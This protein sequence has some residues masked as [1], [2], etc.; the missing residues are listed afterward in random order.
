MK[1]LQIGS[2]N[3]AEQ[4]DQMP[5]GMDWFVCQAKEIPKILEDLKQEALQKLPI[6]EEG[7]E[8]P[9]VRIY[10]DAVL[11]TTPVEESDLV[12]LMNTVEAYGL[13]YDTNLVLHTDN[14]NGIFR[15][16]VLQELP[17]DGSI[18]EKVNYLHL[19]LFGSQ[20][21]AKLKIPDIDINPN[22]DGSVRYD[23]H[24]ALELE[25]NFGEDFQP[26][27]TFRYNLSSFPVALELW[28]EFTKL[29]GDCQIQMEI[30]PM[31]KGGLYDLLPSIILEESDL[32]V[33]YVLDSKP[34]EIGFYAIS[35]FA[36][37]SGKMTFGPLHWRYSRIGLGKFVAGGQR[38]ND[39]S[40]QEFI[41]YFNPGDM[42]PPMNVYFSGYRPAEGFEGFGI[43]KSLK[44]PF[45]L[46]GDPRLEGGA[47]YIG[48][49]ELENKIVEVIQDSLNYLGFESNQLILSGL[50]MGTYGA[51]YYAPNLQPHAVV[52]G[53][54][55]TNLGD[56]AA[57]LKLKRPDEFE[58]SADI[59]LNATGGI[60]DEHI[61]ILNQ[62]FWEKFSSS[63]F[64]KTKFAIAYMENDDYDSHATLRLIEHLS[65][66]GA[67]IYTK[68]YEGRHNDNS[69][70]IN[71][72]FMRQYVDLLEAGFER[73][74]S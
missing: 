74:Y 53:K 51:L 26:L 12:P 27:F 31:R 63:D 15:R 34:E 39:S 50:S 14:P 52:V 60:S 8:L 33:P 36:K 24:V 30:S 6:P 21:G 16:K 64:E 72:W 13:F 70:S 62:K 69:R 46:I 59:L 43:M 65:S 68:G 37:G 40:R 17:I 41:Y 29:S 45:M 61:S 28:L 49:E 3:W 9:K 44:S 18:E 25:G 38:Y 73:K 20:Y 54:P 57:G 55:F 10:F 71:K 19:T 47:F 2:Q 4:I 23:G 1:V 48:S 67:H 11:I 32:Q 56:T 22:F 35:I 66:K 7:E 58:T 5:E 42:K